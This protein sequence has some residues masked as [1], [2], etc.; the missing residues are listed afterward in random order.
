MT[1]SKPTFDDQKSGKQETNIRCYSG[2]T[3]SRFFTTLLSTVNPKVGFFVRNTR[4]HAFSSHHSD[5][6][7]ILPTFML[8]KLIPIESRDIGHVLLVKRA[9]LRKED[10]STVAD[11]GCTSRRLKE[12]MN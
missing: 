1:R 10:C 7:D 4:V 11:N 2:L 3:F 9:L 12:L 6:K 8:G 5:V